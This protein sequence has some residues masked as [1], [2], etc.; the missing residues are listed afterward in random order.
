MLEYAQ[1]FK[2]FFMS[3]IQQII[4]NI[5]H[6]YPTPQ[7]PSQ[8]EDWDIGHKC[9]AYFEQALPLSRLLLPWYLKY[10]MS[11]VICG[12]PTGLNQ[13]KEEVDDMVKARCLGNEQLKK[14]RKEKGKITSTHLIKKYKVSN[15]QEISDIAYTWLTKQGKKCYSVQ[16]SFADSSNNELGYSHVLL[17]YRNDNS[18]QSYRQMIA[19]LNNPHVRALDMLF[20][21][22][23]SAYDVLN[24]LAREGM[25]MVDTES[26]CPLKN[27]DTLQLWNQ[28]LADEQGLENINTYAVGSIQLSVS[29][30][31]KLVLYNKPRNL[32]MDK[33][34]ID[35][36]SQKIDL[37]FQRS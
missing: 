21:R 30:P 19:D 25:R 27:T 4:D 31:K 32:E 6:V 23:G 29:D 35:F 34:M 14:L 10:T 28:N 15:C 20:Q 1:F 12:M 2:G 11:R 16:C 26:I 13:T 17:L 9:L 36:I 3:N 22:C 24:T 33:D 5:K 7:Y 37:S 8:K 18:V